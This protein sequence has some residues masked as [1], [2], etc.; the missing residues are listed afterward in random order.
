L[1]VLETKE[2]ITIDRAGNKANK[3]TFPFFGMDDAIYPLQAHYCYQWLDVE[4]MTRGAFR[5]ISPFVAWSQ[6]GHK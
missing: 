1:S 2:L 3:N 5:G 4:D 6:V